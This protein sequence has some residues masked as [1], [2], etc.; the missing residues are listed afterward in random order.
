MAPCP[1]VRMVL[2]CG[3]FIV[4][5]CLTAAAQTGATAD[6]RGVVIDA[7][8]AVIQ[9]GAVVARSLA[10]NLSRSTVSNN[11]GEYAIPGLPPGVYELTVEAAGFTR[12]VR[13]S[14]ELSVGQAATIDVTLAVPGV[15]QLVLVSTSPLLVEA[16]KTE[17]S[18]TI[19]PLHVAALPVNGR[20]FFDFSL[21]T[22]NVSRGRAN[23]NT[24]L[25]E[26]GISFA[27]LRGQLNNVSVDGLD[28][29]DAFNGSTRAT[30]SQEA[31]QEFRVVNNNFTAD[32]GRAM[33]GL[34]NVLTKSGG[35][36]RH[37]SA[38][39]FVRDARFDARSIL[40][41]G[42]QSDNLQQH[43]FGGVLGGPV[44][45]DELFY[46]ASYEGQRRSQRPQY[47]TFVL[48]NI[49]T[50]NAQL[51]TLGYRS[52]PIDVVETANNNDQILGKLH[53]RVGQTSLTVRYNIADARNPN[54]G[55]GGIS[56]PSNGRTNAVRDQSGV[57]TAVTVLSATLV[58]DLRA[59]MARRQFNNAPVSRQPNL[60]VAGLFVA[61]DQ[62][63]QI[64]ERTEQRFQAADSITWLGNGHTVKIGAELNVV[65]EKMNF[66]AFG[67]GRVVFAGLPGFLNT[68]G[69]PA[70][71]SAATFQV[72][73][74]NPVTTVTQP[75]AEAFAQDEWRVTSRLSLNIGARYTVDLL[76]A[77]M[78][79]RDYNNLQPRVGA[80]YSFGATHATVVRA[81]YG[82][83]VN[84]FPILQHMNPRLFG[85]R[86][87][88]VAR[89]QLDGQVPI[90]SISGAAATGAA[91]AYLT[92]G[93]IPVGAPQFGIPAN[94]EAPNAYSQQASV[95]VERQVTDRL[96]VRVGYV[97]TTGR[98][99]NRIQNINLLAPIAVLPSGKADFQFRSADPAFSAI[100][101]YNSNGHS[102]YNGATVTVEKRLSRRFSLTLNYTASKAMDD[103]VNFSFQNSA[104]NEFEK[105]RE[106][107]RSVE[108]VPHRLTAFGVWQGPDTGVLRGFQ[109]A[110]TAVAESGRFF[111]VTVG[112][113]ANRDF[114]AQTDRPFNLGR[115]TLQGPGYFNLDTRLSRF[116]QVRAVRLELML[117][118][119]NL[120][121]RVNVQAVSG[122]WGSGDS[123]ISS[124]A[125]P[126]AVFNPRQLQLAVRGSF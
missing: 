101:E 53:G 92:D 89:N 67:G 12:S 60:L 80:V 2:V 34:V 76:P 88:R 30:I 73:V 37:G 31:V 68:A 95:Q 24:P 33:G 74:G 94:R 124:F 69:N 126:N 65:H 45:R 7:Q 96:A 41:A 123:P 29:N 119:F 71:F 103:T 108:H 14:L 48:S 91:Y 78:M 110:G 90:T 32:A 8:G 75:T 62:F 47:S 77:D 16:T 85:G 3:F 23:L 46:F 49:G 22:P 39:E 43:Q 87:Y 15:E 70:G 9:G 115:N 25:V 107:A 97:H 105:D 93:T 104:E 81:G 56:L 1:H 52:E 59:Q 54:A 120:L 72:S 42:G 98:N 6:I 122:V 118:A 66:F 114:N 106:W 11:N 102:Q 51:A 36:T 82:A 61:G 57:I 64:R 44:R 116:I 19:S 86:G 27:G 125:T 100:T 109:V 79:D 111:N 35:N 117:E 50:I 10:T 112:A 84:T 13:T 40:T 38:F 83:F 17:Q 28:N 113:D 4:T 58:N 20:N 18:Q 63:D 99:L 121:N 21:L 26:A 55:V 5:T